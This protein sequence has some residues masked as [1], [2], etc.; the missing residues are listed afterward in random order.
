MAFFKTSD[1]VNLFYEEKGEGRPIVL[2][3]GWSGDHTTFAEPIESLSNEFR[4]VAY[5]LR[6]HGQSDRTGQGLTLRRFAQDLDELMEHLGLDEVTLAGHS[7]G[8]ST[9]FEYIRNYSTDRL[10]SFTI[11]DMTPKLVNE[12]GWNLGL[13]HGEYTRPDADRDLTQMYE[14]FEG[15]SRPFMKKTVPYLT[16]EEIEEMLKLSA[17][18]SPHVLAAMWHAMVTADYRDMLAGIKVPAQIVYGDKSTLYSK[19]TAEFLNEQIPHSTVIPFENCTHMLTAEN[20][21]R[22]AEVIRQ[23]AGNPSS[24]A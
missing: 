7:M 18:N 1:G 23:A 21:G 12:D 10:S 14:E 5:D 6:G 2:V 15:F 17:G 4:V 16:E 11:F 3:H 19:E 9:G 22:I 13:W 20:P 8:A 24:Q